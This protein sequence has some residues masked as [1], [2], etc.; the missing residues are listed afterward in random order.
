MP[1]AIP[2]LFI[3]WLGLDVNGSS[4]TGRDEHNTGRPNGVL[5]NTC[6]AAP[7]EVNITP[8]PG[9]MLLL[10]PALA[11]LGRLRRNRDPQ[12]ASAA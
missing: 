1:A 10:A 8:E 6:V 3:G 2:R 9:T 4:E 11:A 7:P 5:A 12:P